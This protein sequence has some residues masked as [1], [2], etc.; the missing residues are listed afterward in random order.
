MEGAD[1]VDY[2]VHFSNTLDSDYRSLREDDVVEFNAA[3]GKHGKMQA[4]EVVVL[5]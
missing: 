2:F 4:L 5:N 3:P 1:G